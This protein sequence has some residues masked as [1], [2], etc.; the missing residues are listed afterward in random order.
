MKQVAWLLLA[1]ICTVGC[2]SDTQLTGPFRIPATRLPNHTAAKLSDLT[3]EISKN[4][5]PENKPSPPENDKR[6]SA[7]VAQ[8]VP[9]VTN[10]APKDGSANLLRRQVES[11]RKS[12]AGANDPPRHQAPTKSNKPATPAPPVTAKQIEGSLVDVR[13]TPSTSTNQIYPG[14]SKELLYGMA[15]VFG[16]LFTSI[17][18]PLIVDLIR[19]RIWNWPAPYAFPNSERGF[20]ERDER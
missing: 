12:I 6:R 16:A 3:P 20:G 17:L 14:L 2:R 1:A 11:S 15:A 9:A 10:R 5:P 13:E 18:A 7:S 19:Q 4:K 8:P